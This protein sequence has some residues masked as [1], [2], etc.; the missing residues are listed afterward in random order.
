MSSKDTDEVCLIHSKSGKRG[1]LINEKVHEVI[2]NI[3]Q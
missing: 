1:I 2:E 3:F